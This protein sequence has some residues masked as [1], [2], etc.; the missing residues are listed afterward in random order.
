MDIRLDKRH[1]ADGSKE[2]EYRTAGIP[3]EDYKT[4][5]L[6]APLAD[7]CFV[8]KLIFCFCGSLLLQRLLQMFNDI[9]TKDN[10]FGMLVTDPTTKRPCKYGAVMEVRC[11]V[12]WLH[13]CVDVFC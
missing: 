3:T 6:F 4:A 1:P 10:R 8:V 9:G 12:S 5:G 11:E 13:S 2:E 7:H